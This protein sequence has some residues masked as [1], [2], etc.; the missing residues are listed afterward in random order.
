MTR[1][2]M[3][4]GMAGTIALALSTATWA[5]TSKGIE[6]SVHDLS[7]ASWNTRQGVCSPCHA[8]HHTDP[9]Q[10]APLWNHKTTT[11]TFTPYNNANQSATMNASVG[12]PNGPSLACLSCHDGVLGVNDTLSNTNAPVP[13]D[14]ATGAVLGTDL[15][16]THPISFQY[17]ATLAANDGG[18]ANPD[19]YQ[20]GT[21]HAALSYAYAPAPATW[22]GTPLSGKTITQALLFGDHYMECSSCHDVH[23]IDGASPSS[24]IMARISGTDPG[25]KGSTLCRTC[26]VK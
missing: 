23:K 25:N 8:A 17:T 26:H 2:R 10:I 22:S 19:T 7:A 9:A 6:N 16:T 3:I 24:G 21:P 5:A 12:Q 14:P 18:L 20:I 13:I 1:S 15:H 11:S 4:G